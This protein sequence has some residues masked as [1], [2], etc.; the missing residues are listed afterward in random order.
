MTE[1]N[2]SVQSAINTVIDAG[3]SSVRSVSVDAIRRFIESQPDVSGNVS[4]TPI[5]FEKEGGA[6]S[7]IVRF[8]ATYDHGDG[9]RTEDLVLRHAPGSERALFHEYDLTRQFK[10]QRVLHSHGLP[11]PQ[12]KWLDATGEFL[13]VP[14]YVMHTVSGE[15]PNASAFTRGPIA[16]ANP[17]QRHRMLSAVMDVLVKIHRLDYHKEGLQDFTMNAEG[18]TPLERNINWYWKTWEWIDLP[19]FA[20]LE[21]VRRWLL[22]NAPQ[23]D[24]RL[25]HGDSSLHNY[26]FEDGKLTAVLDWELSTLARPEADLALQRVTTELFAPPPESGLLMPPSEEEWLALYEAA[27]GLP[28]RDFE[29]FKKYSMFAILIAML[30]L[31]RNLPDE[32]RAGLA[33][34]RARLWSVIES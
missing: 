16:R 22:A 26:L 18:N 30:S 29:Y 27:G 12:P 24:T 23:G 10:V 3:K 14:G 34:F 2:P 4:V 32:A 5:E 13:G 33:S 11:V 31:Q 6:S 25:T 28:P 20:R 7:G 9:I 8:S 21:P 17:E 19:E 1:S 15:A